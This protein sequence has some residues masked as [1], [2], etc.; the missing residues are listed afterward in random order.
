MTGGAAPV[1]AG[2]TRAEEP[3]EKAARPLSVVQVVT[4][5]GWSS[6]AWASVA[7]CLG[8]QSEGH[9]V[10]LVCREV[11][12]GRRVAERARREGVREVDF[13]E[14]SGNFRPASYLRDLKRLRALARERSADVI[15]LHRG[16]EHWLAA[17]AFLGK[18]GPALIRS[19]HILRPVRRHLFNRWLYRSGTDRV[20]TVCEKI[21]EGYLAGGGFPPAR[22]VTVMGGVDASAYAPEEEGAAFRKEWGIPPGAWLVGIAGNLGIW[23][24]GQDVLLRAAARLARE[25][26]DPPWVAVIG[27]GVD[28]GRLE[29]LAAELGIA[30]R[31]VFPGYLENLAGAFAACD[32]LAFSSRRSEGTS[33]VLFEYLAAGRPVVASRVGCTDEIVREAKEGFL[34][35]PEDEEALAGALARLRENPEAARVM[36]ASARRRAEEEF[37]RRVMARRTVEIYRQAA[38]DR[39]ATRA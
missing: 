30:E 26:G 34:V 22:F 5:R 4:C 24:K 1:E 10:L 2:R 14:A 36:G 28:R 20:V 38:R 18:G 25:G 39:S 31:T 37:D 17:A 3:P 12:G 8:L 32:A 15:H 6:D 7:L 19:R 35:P 16:M 27:E 29:A 21:R 13:I 23:L 11:D 33:R 9:R